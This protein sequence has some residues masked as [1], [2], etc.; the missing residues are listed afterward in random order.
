MPV[1]GSQQEVI[2]K[3]LTMT[4]LKGKSQLLVVLEIHEV[5]VDK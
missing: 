1:L 5:E 2:S 3:A 4:Y